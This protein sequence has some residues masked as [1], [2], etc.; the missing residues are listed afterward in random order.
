MNCIARR[1][2]AAKPGRRAEPAHSLSGIRTG[3]QDQVVRA[4]PGG[5]E[6]GLC[7][8]GRIGVVE[9]G[10]RPAGGVADQ[11]PAHRSLAA[12]AATADGIISMA[13]SGQ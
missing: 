6:L 12:W 7:G 1:I 10:Q 11:P 4:D 13:R 5:L 2:R 9:D 8:L 3:Q